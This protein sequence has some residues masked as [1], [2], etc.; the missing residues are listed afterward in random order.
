ML[1]FVIAVIFIA[2]MFLGSMYDLQITSR[3]SK[4]TQNADGVYSISPGKLALAFA[5]IGRWTTPFLGAVSFLI[6]ELNLR[7]KVKEKTRMIL[8]VVFT[9]IA[10]AFMFYGSNKTSFRFCIRI[11]DG[12]IAAHQRFQEFPERFFRPGVFPA[13]LNNGILFQMV[14]PDSINRSAT[15]RR[16]S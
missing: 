3:L 9:V 11:A 5:L 8:F 13:N 10:A 14:P 1:H 4:L 2:G 16:P 15:L 6:T 7:R 12:D